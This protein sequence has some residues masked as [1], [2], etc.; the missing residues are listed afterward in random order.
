MLGQHSIRIF[1]TI[2]VRPKINSLRQKFFTMG[3]T[4]CGKMFSETLLKKY[5]K[6][7]KKHSNKITNE[8]VLFCQRKVME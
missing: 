3:K 8:T 5:M 4:L 6:P 1:G 7:V 2:R